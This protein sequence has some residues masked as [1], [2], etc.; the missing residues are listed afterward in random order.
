[1]VPL[2][3]LV[4]MDWSYRAKEA[5]SIGWGHQ[6]REDMVS[7]RGCHCPQERVIC[8]GQSM[9]FGLDFN[10]WEGTFQQWPL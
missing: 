3:E 4:R 2:E 8:Y 7:V 1:M 10:E 5:N 9:A 6:P